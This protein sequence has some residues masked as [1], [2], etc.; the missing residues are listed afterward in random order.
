MSDAHAILRQSA[1]FVRADNWGGA[2]RFHGLKIFHQAVFLC[3]G[4]GGK[5]QTD[6]DCG[7]QAFR[8]VR[9][10]DADEEDDSLEP[11]VANAKGKNEEDGAQGGGEQGHQFDEVLDLQSN[12]GL[13]AA[14]ASGEK[15]N[16][17]NEG[18]VTGS[19]DHASSSAFGDVR[20]EE[21]NVLR[22]QRVL[23]GAL[24]ASL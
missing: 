24:V 9:H 10:N 4:L 17:A 13:R 20:W 16:L 8:H 23:M 7:Q 18:R 21:G 12:G 15:G 3:H 11:V 14:Q 2:K 19:N 1:R 6:G 22:L 5:R